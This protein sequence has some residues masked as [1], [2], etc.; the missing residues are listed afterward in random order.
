M[1]KIEEKIIRILLVLLILLSLYFSYNIWLDPSG[2]EVSET[3]E[4]TMVA[5]KTPASD[6]FLPM[7]LISHQNGEL[8]WVRGENLVSIFQEKLNHAKFGDLRVLVEGNEQDY[9]KELNRKNAFELL[10]EGN[11]LL[12]EYIKTFDL[13]LN[14]GSSEMSHFPFRRVLVDYDGGVILF[15]NDQKNQIYEATISMNYNE[16]LKKLKEKDVH[17]QKVSIN[18]DV[19]KNRYYID[20]PITMK[21]YSYILASQPYT[22]FRDAFFTHPGDVTTNEE[23]KDLIYTGDNNETMTIEEVSGSLR[24]RGTVERD[25][26][27]SSNIYNQSFPYVSRLGGVFSGIRY[28]NTSGEHTVI[29]RTFIE[30][31]PVFSELSKGKVEVS[32]TNISGTETNITVETSVDTIQVPIPADAEVTLPPTS[33]VVDSLINYGADLK[34]VDSIVV[35]YSWTSLNV[36]Q[37]V[38]LMPT[39][40]VHY[41]G[42]WLPYEELLNR[43]SEEGSE[44]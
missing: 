35:G 13:E 22:N 14:T 15:A 5:D 8:F 33:E 11:Y 34:K 1:T 31:F 28:F 39:W 17:F 7:D 29:Y 37:V 6:I 16:L 3:P 4:S 10:Y 42:K 43:L 44:G 30:G 23:T 41:D 24:Y 27:K 21:K 18:H 40:F 32:A 38:D 20:E 36:K 26:D 2:K 12:S 9:L 19:L 25:S